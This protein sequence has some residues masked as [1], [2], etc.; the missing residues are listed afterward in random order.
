MYTYK[1]KSARVIDGDTTEAIISLGFYIDITIRVRFAGL[2]TPE[3][4]SPILEERELAKLAKYETV[5]WFEANKGNI[6][7][8]SKSTDKYGR[9]IGRFENWNKESI[10]DILLEK[11]LAVKYL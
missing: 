1:V 11:N 2:N 8:Y 6:I 9:Y 4:N 10:N 5:A 7:L 3:L